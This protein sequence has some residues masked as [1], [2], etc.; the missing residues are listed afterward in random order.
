MRLFDTK[1]AVAY[2]KDT[3]KAFECLKLDR[4]PPLTALLREDGTVTG[5][6]KEMDGILRAKWSEVFCK[7]DKGRAFPKVET[8]IEKFGRFIPSSPMKANDLTADMIIFQIRKYSDLG[9]TGMDGW[10]PRDIKRLPKS[11][12][13]YLVYFK[14]LVEGCGEWPSMLTHAAVSFIP[15]GEGLDPLNLRPLSVL[16]LVYRAWAA[17]R[18]SQCTS[19]QE[20]WI[21]DG[22]H[23]ARKGHSCSE[24]YH[25]ANGTGDGG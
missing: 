2:E 11:V 13:H 5:N 9:A 16:P 18:C 23:G 3:M 15:K 8:F 20:S 10:S 6:I 4:E 25:R 22:Q 7:H 1:K 14:R 19:W 17:I 21:T 12:F 24:Q